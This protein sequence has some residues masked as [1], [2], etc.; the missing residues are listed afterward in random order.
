MQKSLFENENVVEALNPTL[1]I[2]SVSGC[3][4]PKIILHLC[5]DLGSDSLFYQLSDEYEVIMIGEEIGVENYN[6]PPNVYGI[7]ANPVCTEFST[8]N[9]FHKQNDLEKGMFLVNHC[10]R[11]IKEAKPKWWVIENPANGRLK[12]F[13]GKPRLV[14]QPWEYGSPWTKKTALWGEFN[15]PEKKYTDW[16]KVPKNDKLYIRPGRPKP[17]LAFLHKSAVDLIPEMRWAKDKIKC[18]ADIRS[19]CSAGFAEAFF[20]NNR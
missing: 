9:G 20:Q 19:M 2:C 3:S 5:A 8:A 17:A 6:P 15:I 16:N 14:Y 11:I 4:S 13:L 12:E 10:L 1:R 18:D 7:I